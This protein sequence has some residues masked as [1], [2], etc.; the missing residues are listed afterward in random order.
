MCREVPSLNEKI[1]DDVDQSSD[2]VGS[3]KAVD[4]VGCDSGC[5]YEIQANRTQRSLLVKFDG[6][7][8]QIQ[9]YLRNSM[10]T[11]PIVAVVMLKEVA[12]SGTGTI[13]G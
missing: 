1:A 2:G 4:S 11:E 5:I 3:A 8:S 6:E 7:K 12:L 13:G 9:A 10:V